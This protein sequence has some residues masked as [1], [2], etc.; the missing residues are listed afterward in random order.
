MSAIKGLLTVIGPCRSTAGYSFAVKAM[1]HRQPGTALVSAP[2]RRIYLFGKTRESL[3]EAGVRIWSFGIPDEERSDALTLALNGRLEIEG[4]SRWRDGFHIVTDDRSGKLTLVRG[5]FDETPVCWT[6]R[7]NTLFVAPERKAFASPTRL[8]EI[9][10]LDPGYSLSFTP[11]EARATLTDGHRQ[12]PPPRKSLADSDV[13]EQIECIIRKWMVA[14]LETAPRPLAIALSGG[15]DS[16]IAAW[17]ATDLGFRPPA[18]S[19]WYDDGGELSNDIVRARRMAAILGLEH[20][21]I[22]VTRSDLD[23]HIEDMIRRSE[24]RSVIVI[25]GSLHWQILAR[26]MAED[27]I[28]TCI[29][30]QGSDHIFASFPEIQKVSPQADPYK[31]WEFN[32][33]MV[34]RDDRELMITDSY[35]LNVLGAFKSP[36]LREVALSLPIELLW[37]VEKEGIQGKQ[38]LRK[39]FS[40]RLP[41]EVIEQSKINVHLVDNLGAMLKQSYGDPPDRRRRY[42]KLRKRLLKP[43]RPARWKFI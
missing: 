38:I 8:K 32:V 28:G 15:L 24:A 5:E 1:A 34:V 39:A 26:R 12:W 19:V 33:R 43:A 37:T 42:E 31:Q 7:E 11:K 27:G 41:P 40:N 35:G 10:S 16:S 21:E 20:R 2:H 4:P 14:K 36:E 6:V 3:G 29:S 13:A 9:Q 30:G 23:G 18:Y 17:M 22:H 25:E